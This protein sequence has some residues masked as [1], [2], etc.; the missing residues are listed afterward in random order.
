M[1]FVYHSIYNL[2]SYKNGL[3]LGNYTKGVSYNGVKKDQVS[4]LEH[5][6]IPSHVNRLPVICTAYK[7]LEGMPNLQT[8]FVPYTIEEI[9]GD[10]FKLCKKL[11][12]ITFEVNSRLKKINQWVFY[13]S[14]LVSIS[15][16]RSLVSINNHDFGM[17]S[18]L[19]SIEINNFVHSVDTSI[20]YGIDKNVSVLVPVNYPY[21]TFGGI[22]VMKILPF[23]SVINYCKTLKYQRCVSQS[24][25]LLFVLVFLI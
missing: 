13:Q 12:S 20:F 9:G 3:I 15:F 14:G 23:Y 6:V 5:A 4:L 25:H 17:C 2:Y 1:T 22:N 18:E 7:S 21:D 8:V 10:T 11:H 16:P 24:R 19:R